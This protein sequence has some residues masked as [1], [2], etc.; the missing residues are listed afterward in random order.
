MRA[1][2]D[3]F[4]RAGGKDSCG[5]DETDF[6]SHATRVSRGVPGC[7][8]CGMVVAGYTDQFGARADRS[9]CQTAMHIIRTLPRSPDITV[10]VD[11]SIA[12]AN[13]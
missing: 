7:D 13:R 2:A 12:A 4:V 11:T 1:D 6:A 8:R 5:E 3:F 9:E 10:A